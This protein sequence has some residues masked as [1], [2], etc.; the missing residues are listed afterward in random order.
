MRW[1]LNFVFFNRADLIL[2]ILCN[3]QWLNEN[4]PKDLNGRHA[5]EPQSKKYDY[6]NFTIIEIIN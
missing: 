1:Q 5:S 3:S 6:G 4:W 2:G